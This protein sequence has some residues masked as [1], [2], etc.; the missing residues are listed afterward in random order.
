MYS[1]RRLTPDERDRQEEA[2]A[3]RYEDLYNEVDAQ[4][5]AENIL[6]GGACDYKPDGAVVH[7]RLMK[8]MCK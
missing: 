8:L 1:I 5:V 2:A 6:D 4:M 7:Q 3:D